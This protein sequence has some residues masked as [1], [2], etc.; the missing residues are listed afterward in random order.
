[1]I[2]QLTS[3]YVPLVDLIVINGDIIEWNAVDT[4]VVVTFG[5]HDSAPM[6]CAN[7]DG[8]P[9]SALECDL[10]QGKIT[11]D[12][13]IRM[14][15]WKSV[16]KL[17]T[18]SAH[19]CTAQ[20][21]HGVGNTV[22]T[23]SAEL[24]FNKAGYSDTLKD[25]RLYDWVRPSQVDWM[26][27]VLSRIS[28]APDIMP[29]L[30]FTH[31]PPALTTAS[32]DTMGE[33]MEMDS[34]VKASKDDTTTEECPA[35][36]GIFFYDGASLDVKY[37]NHE[38]TL[39]QLAASSPHIA[40]LFSGHHHDNDFC[41]TPPAGEGKGSL[42]FCYGG[43]AGYSAATHPPAKASGPRPRGAILERQ[44]T[45]SGVTTSTTAQVPSV[46][47]VTS[48]LPTIAT[49]MVPVVATGTHVI[50]STLPAAAPTHIVPLVPTLGTSEL[51]GG[52]A[53]ETE[54]LLER[55]ERPESTEAQ[56]EK[57]VSGLEIADEVLADLGLESP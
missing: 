30:I 29:G 2:V 34:K 48:T 16:Q 55:E 4:K 10:T 26:R 14:K 18:S 35:A 57:A 7:K 54:G 45:A 13:E 40:A 32:I 51:E 8:V 25:E 41:A 11:V 12:Q 19:L 27:G 46:P 6:Q 15:R 33:W 28:D 50:T 52:A 44:H 39:I 56:A 42:A 38:Q 21:T 31:H 43:T 5:N 20:N 17:F 36:R 22:V 49:P 24:S 1:M 9:P 23:G 53:S 47:L 37:K 3:A